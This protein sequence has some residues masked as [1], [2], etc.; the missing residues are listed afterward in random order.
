VRNRFEGQTHWALT[1]PRG[2]K[3]GFGD[4]GSMNLSR[5]INSGEFGCLTSLEGR[6]EME[7]QVM[8]PAHT[9]AA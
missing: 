7:H 2:P 6:E 9:E 8:S 5:K 1:L 3:S 4:H